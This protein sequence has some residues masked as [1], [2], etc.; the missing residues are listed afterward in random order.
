M[1]LAENQLTGAEIKHLTK[2]ASTLEVLKLASNKITD[3]KDVKQLSCF[4]KLK[5][6]DLE[7]N[8][9]TKVDG[10][11]EKIWALFEGASLEILD[12]HNKAGEEAFSEDLDEDDYGSSL[13]DEA[14]AKFL[15][16]GFYGDE[17]GFE[18][19]EDDMDDLENDDDEDENE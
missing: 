18:G 7:N 6:L 14:K 1:E 3:I 13:D 19:G 8:D 10:Y 11:K 9:V 17:G 5:N 4:K 2:Y 12:N 15:E 16:D